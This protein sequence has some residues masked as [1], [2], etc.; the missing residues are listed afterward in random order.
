MI[1]I[2]SGLPRSGTSLM[3]QILKE[4]G[5]NLLTDNIREADENN[6]RGYYEFE[7]VK[8]MAIDNSWL[9]NADGKVIKIIAQLL[10][11]L[12]HTFDYKIIFMERDYSEVI[13]SQN[14]MI[15]NLGTKNQKMDAELLKKIFLKQVVSIKE[16]LVH[17]ENCSVEF[18]NFKDLIFDS[19]NTIEK[20]NRFMNQNLNEE[21]MLS[22]I[23]PQLYRERN[24]NKMTSENSYKKDCG[25]PQKETK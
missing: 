19:K 13:N 22:A 7:K 12:P 1:T 24:F 18:I 16:M 25:I 4:G 15:K 10:R 17:Q 11:F 3:M 2:V 6:Q 23:I 5:M 8:K 14:K 21:K 9:V 20:I